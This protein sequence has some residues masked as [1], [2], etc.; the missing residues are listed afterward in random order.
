MSTKINVRSPFYLNLTEPTKPTPLFTCELA[1]IKNLSID[2]QGQ[3]STPNLDYGTVL[4]ITSSD[5]DFVD[6]KFATETVDTDRVVVV[7]VSIPAG[8]SNSTD[9]FINCT[10][11]VTQP[12]YVSG[13]TCSGGVTTTGSI[14]AVTITTSGNSTS[15]DLSNYFVA[16][17]DPIA[18]YNIY[19]PNPSLV[20]ASINGDWITVSSNNLAG[21]TTIQI[22]AY[23]NG[24]DTCTATQ[25]LEVTVSAPLE[26]FNCTTA[27]LTGGYIAQDGTITS[28]NTHATIDEIRS[29]SGG[30]AISSYSANN[31][32]SDRSVTLYFYLIVPDGYT[33]AGSYY[34]CSKVLTQYAGDPEFTCD[35]A[36]LSGQQISSKGVINVGTLQ[37]GTIDS[38]SPNFFAEVSSDTA[39]QVTFTI[40]IPSGYSNTSDL[41][42][43]CTKLL[44]QPAAIPVCGTSTYYRSAP[45]S[46]PSKACSDVYS[47][48]VE[49]KSTAS[50]VETGLGD[51][52]CQSDAPF[53][54]KEFWYGISSNKTSI[55]L[56][57]GKF[58]L[59]QIDS[60]GVVMD[61][62]L[63]NCPTDGSDGGN[64]NIGYI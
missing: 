11:V 18:G 22:S 4:S 42:I 39:R 33:N 57:T 21:T 44:T 28:P 2:Q 51:T 16:G 32:G 23:D 50:S 30:P 5:A 46:A 52:S 37:L 10:K 8:F 13:T 36:N 54:G 20:N 45:L 38:F 19:N 24:T 61:V 12:A 34:E 59:W 14:G 35:T 27:N 53:D 1:N 62:V 9:G 63:V 56:G 41:T 3:L 60:N 64:G 25:G 48:S 49:M 55:G 29:Y 17:S 58:Y 6:N 7:K 31:T 47:V 26:S 15:I 43:D 40:N